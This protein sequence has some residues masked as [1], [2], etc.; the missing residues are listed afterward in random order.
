MTVWGFAAWSGGFE[1]LS[2]VLAA[3]A[4]WTSTSLV[5]FQCMSE[6]PTEGPLK[7]A[8]ARVSEYVEQ[9][10]TR[11]PTT[12]FLYEKLTEA[13]IYSLWVL[14]VYIDCLSDDH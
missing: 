7:E 2:L 14:A 5:S 6:P 12:K 8:H 1:P 11:N 10:L 9:S 13:G 4:Q 3:A